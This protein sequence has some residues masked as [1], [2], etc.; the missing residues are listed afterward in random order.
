MAQPTDTHGTP[1]WAAIDEPA[2]A[3]TDEPAGTHADGTRRSASGSILRGGPV[4]SPRYSAESIERTVDDH[5]HDEP[6]R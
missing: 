1:F 5:Q 3:H 4:G 6:G 2:G